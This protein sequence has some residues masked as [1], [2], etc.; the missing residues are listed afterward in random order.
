MSEQLSEEQVLLL[1]NLMYMNPPLTKI[2]DC[3]TSKEQLTVGDIL[4]NIDIDALDMKKDYGSYMTGQDWKNIITAIESD[5]QL[6]NVELVSTNIDRAEN[7]G[8]GESAL[9]ADPSTGEAIV[10]FRGTSGKEWKDNFIGGGKTDAADG[11][12]TPQ[13]INALKWYESLDLSDYDTVTVTGHSKGGMKA[14]YIT[15][16]DD[17]VDRCLSFDGQGFSDEF[18]HVYRDQIVANQVKIQNCNVE[19]D[20]VNLLLNDIGK[21]TFYEGYDYGEGGFL[22]NHCPNTFFNFKSDGSF[23][24][25]E[26]N[27]NPDMVVLDEFLNNYLRTLSS[28]DKQNTLGLIGD[29]VEAGFAGASTQELMDMLL[30]DDN[31]DYAANLLAYII[32][33]EQ[34]NPELMD[35]AKNIFKQMQMDSFLD[36]L[37]TVDNVL[38][39]KY[40]DVLLGITGGIVGNLSDGILQKLSDLLEDNIGLKLS[41]EDLKKLLGMVSKVSYDMDHIEIKDNGKDISVLNKGSYFVIYINRINQIKPKKSIMYQN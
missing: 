6:L 1:N 16:R 9:F 34:E 30:E 37:D 12:S 7:G 33:Y 40:F 11:V 5:K 41:N 35:A 39:W 32:K 28:E 36:I 31:T 15:V 23:E 3:D 26:G 14:K 21:T 38:N 25:K 22:E 8:G 2:A 20:Y 18:M 27:R 4:E 13:Q 24:M 19:S 17:S 29:L 10:A